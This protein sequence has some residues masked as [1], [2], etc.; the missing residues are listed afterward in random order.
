[1]E[2]I[3]VALKNCHGIRE[4]NTSFTFKKGNAVAIY[5]PNGTMKTSFA[6]TFKDFSTGEETADQVFPSRQTERSISDEQGREL[7]PDDVVV[8]PSYDEELQPTELT[9]TLL[10][11]S[12][13]RKEYEDLQIGLIEA[14]NNL[15]SA[16]K[17]Q[18]KTKQDIVST[19]SRVFTREDGGFIDAMLQIHHEVEQLEDPRF[20]DLSY[21][22]IFNEKVAAILQDPEIQSKLGEYCYVHRVFGHGVRCLFGHGIHGGLGH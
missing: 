13:L 11:N 2:K 21:D 10:V 7:N 17:S 15:V 1:M 3:N 14:R 8:V 4:L 5:A 12:N 19:V 20:G 18:S 16:L 6:R 9:S 22:I